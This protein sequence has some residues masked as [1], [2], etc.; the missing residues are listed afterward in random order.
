MRARFLITASLLLFTVSV[1]SVTTREEAKTPRS[2]PA[3]AVVTDAAQGFTFRNHVIPVLTKAGCNSGACHGAASG[4]N[5][6]SLTLR[7]YDPDADYNALT[8]EAAGRRVNKLEPAKSLVLLKPTETVPHM[9]GKRFEPESPEYRV[10][11]RWIAAGMP[12]PN[13]SDPK[14]LGLEVSPARQT[15]AVGSKTTLKVI[16]R[17]SNG[18]AEDVSRWARYAAADETVAQVDQ[19]GAVTIK[20]HGETAVNVGYLTG[21][22]SVRIA[23]P[24]PHEI[25]AD[26]YTRAERFNFIDDHVLAKLRDLHVAPSGIASDSAFIR[27]AWL[28]A[29]G[30]LP[31]AEEV[32]RFLADTSPSAAKRA[33]LVDRILASE[34][35]VDY[36]SYKW[37]DLLL[38][39]SGKLARSNVRAFY[40]WIRESVAANKPWDRFAYEITTAT[41]RSSEEGAVNFFVIHRNQI[42]LTE[43]FTQAFL[44]ISMTCARCHNHPLEK[45]TQRDYYAF[46]NL[47]SRVQVKQD[48]DSSKGDAALVVNSASGEIR[49]PR[50]GE[51]LTPKPLDGKPMPS[52]AQ[53][54]MDRRVYLGKWLTAPDNPLF[55]RT[56]V[57]RVWGNFFGRGLVTPVDDLRATNPASNDELFAAVTKDFVARGY[58]VK[59]LMRTIMLSAA[60]QRSSEPNETNAGDDRF[61]SRF[62][63]RRLPAEVILDAISQVTGVPEKFAGYPLG[64]RALQLP[65]TRVPSYFLDIFGRPER[66]ATSAAERMQDPTL[67]QALHV[68]NGDT[69]QLKLTDADGTIGRFAREKVSDEQAIERLYLAALSRKPSADETSKI[70]AVLKASR[71]D[72]AASSANETA[73]RQAALEDL[74]W[75]V[76]TSK[77]FLFNH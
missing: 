62:I 53:P 17:Y 25:P 10:I 38:V 49:H 71:A 75:A 70:A 15:L 36:W 47:F 45:W 41:G 73:T 55:A 61:Y 19:F 33:A 58:D 6:F 9:G 5:G 8:R 11:A 2:A 68:I 44:G 40:R 3:A 50:T 32:E 23:S 30:V 7:G 16:A 12:A 18:V 14:L 76:F 27:R 64:T 48:P 65:D 46:A 29:A 57:N 60:Y 52:H 59:Q 20:G 63:V 51:V 69:L 4:K 72:A 39:S 77:E 67:T 21:V 42:D 26:V 24:F 34:P 74:A 35:W 22:S 56:V 1:K 66:K 31:P 54:E 28:D 37:S 13:T 43:N